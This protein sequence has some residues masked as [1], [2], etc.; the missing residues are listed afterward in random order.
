V[1][2]HYNL[3]WRTD[4]SAINLTHYSHGATVNN[5]RIVNVKS[6]RITDVALTHTENGS[7]RVM[8]GLKVVNVIVEYSL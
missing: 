1:P 4:L 3:M 8:I 7:L 5:T 6:Y 2:A